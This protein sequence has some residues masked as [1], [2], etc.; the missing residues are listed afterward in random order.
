MC[1]ASRPHPTSIIFQTSPRGETP[2][3]KLGDET[4]PDTKVPSTV[5][6][7]WQ[8]KMQACNKRYLSFISQ[9]RDHSRE[10]TDLRKITASVKDDKQRSYRR[11][12]FF[13]SED[14]SFMLAI[15]RG[16]HQD[17]R[18][19]QSNPATP[20]CRMEFSENRSCFE[21][22]PSTSTDQACRAYLQIL[23]FI[24]GQKSTGSSSA[25]KRSSYSAHYGYRM[26]H[27]QT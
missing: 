11:V 18:L 16:E 12:N 2:G 10:R 19:H 3:R 14:L 1:F 25:I 21:K 9:W 5:W 22:V 26:N 27:A 13:Q 20:S 8:N 23:S 7:P 24:I 15:L 6:V 17:R 4:C